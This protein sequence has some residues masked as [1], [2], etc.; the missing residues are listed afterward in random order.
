M[1]VRKLQGV[2]LIF[3]RFVIRT[4]KSECLLKK[5][6]GLAHNDNGAKGSMVLVFQ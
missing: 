4:C 6:Q 5:P 1:F 2:Y 3:A